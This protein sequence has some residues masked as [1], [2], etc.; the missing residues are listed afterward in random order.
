[1]ASVIFNG[2]PLNGD[3]VVDET[4]F[5]NADYC[6]QTEMW[7][8]IS[9]TLAEEAAWKFGE[10]NGMDL[11]TIHPGFV[12]GPLLQPN[13]N[14]TSE[15]ISNLIKTGDDLY[16]DGRYRYVDVRDVALAH[17]KA[18][19]V[20]SAKGRYLLVGTVTYSTEVTRILQQLYPALDLPNAIRD[21]D[22]EKPPLYKVSNEKAKSLGID[23]LPLEV[24]VKDTFESLVEKNFLNF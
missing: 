19:E 14:I 1:M 9:K 7:Y 22:K 3:V 2:K 15:A 24:S 5:S 20:P 18:F 23:F 6:R 11:I 4:W 16:F 21:G 12:I 10:E 8:M 17:I 13:L